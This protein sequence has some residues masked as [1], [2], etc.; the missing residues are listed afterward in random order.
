M[1]QH[2]NKYL[3][4]LFCV[5]SL[6]II[7]CTPTKPE[8]GIGGFIKGSI[9]NVLLK[10]IVDSTLSHNIR[11]HLDSFSKSNSHCNTIKSISSKGG[12]EMYKEIFDLTGK[13]KVL[14]ILL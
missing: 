14:P 9:I 10:A 7:S 8:Q 13:Y 12:S 6:S 3:G 11:L 1:K 4:G 2:K 5:V